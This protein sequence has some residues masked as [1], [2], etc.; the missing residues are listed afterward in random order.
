MAE[1]TLGEIGRRLQ[2]LHDDITG[3]MARHD[4]ELSRIRHRQ[5]NQDTI[6]AGYR[7]RIESH[8]RHLEAHNKDIDRI[9]TFIGKL[10]W[11]TIAAFGTVLL[12][13]LGLVITRGT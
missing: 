12:T 6:M 7:E 5:N 13:V 3:V 9:D 2:S 4:E 1:P 11:S 8:Q 10:M